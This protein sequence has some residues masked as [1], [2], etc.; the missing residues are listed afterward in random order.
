MKTHNIWHYLSITPTLIALFGI[1]I[2]SIL[3][4]ADVVQERKLLL[5]AAFAFADFITILAGLGGI[6]YLFNPAKTTHAKNWVWINVGLF[7]FATFTGV[8]LFMQL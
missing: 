6:I 2:F 3:I 4:L 1:T 8:A 7:F 5:V